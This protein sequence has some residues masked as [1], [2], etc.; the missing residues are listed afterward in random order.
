V[1]ARVRHQL[2]TQTVVSKLPDNV[3]ILLVSDTNRDIKT[4]AHGAFLSQGRLCKVRRGLAHT[5][6]KVYLQ[7]Q[8]F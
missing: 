4:H 8:D 1:G 7:P 6:S 2:A 5:R 3:D